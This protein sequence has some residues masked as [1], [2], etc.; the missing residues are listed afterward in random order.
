[1][2]KSDLR[3]SLLML[4]IALLYACTSKNITSTHMPQPTGTIVNDSQDEGEGNALE[5]EL[6][7]E[8][9]H[10]TA[11]GQ[12]WRDIERKNAIKK[13]V[14]TNPTRDNGLVILGDSLYTG[15]WA[16][17]GSKNQAGS[18]IAVEYLV[19][20]NKIYTISSGGTLW[21]GD[22]DGSNWEVINESFIFDS[23]DLRFIDLPN[24][25]KRMIL[26]IARIPH[27][28]DDMG[29]TWTAS[30]GVT[31]SGDF[32][33]R[34]GKF[35]T[36]TLADGSTRLYCLSKYDFWTNIDMYVSEDYGQ[37]YQK[38]RNMFVRDFNRIAFCK[39]HHGN[40]ILI[41]RANAPDKMRIDK[42]DEENIDLSFL[43]ITDVNLT[44]VT[45]QIILIA[46]YQNQDSILYAVQ[47]QNTLMRSN[48]MGQT[49]QSTAIFQDAPWDVGF[50]VSP[51]NPNA[52]YYG[53]VEAH[54]LSGSNFQPVNFWWEYYDDVV[55]YIHADIMSYNEF[56][57]PNGD[58]FLLIANH[59]GLSISR[60][61]LQTTRNISLEG[62][63]VSQYYDVVTDPNNSDFA[64]AGTQDQG[65]QRSRDMNSPGI[66][67]F[68]QVISGDYGHLTFSREGQGLW[69]V[70]PGGTIY[71]YNNPQ[72][73]FAV[74]T[75]E[76]ES[77]DES[78]WLP[79][80][81]AIPSSTENE[82]LVAGGSIDGGAGSHIIKLNYFGGISA[83]QFPFNFTENSDD[84]V[85]TSIEVSP[86]NPNIIYAATNNGF[87]FTSTDGGQNFE[88]G[89]N[90]VNNGHFLYGASIYAST[91]NENEVWIAGSGYNGDGVFYSDDFGQNFSLFTEGLPST[92]VFEIAANADETQFYAATEAGPYIYLAETQRWEDMSQGYTPAHTYWSVEYIESLD[93]VRFGTYGRGIWD[94]EF[95][96]PVSVNTTSLPLHH[97]AKV[98]PNPVQD[99]LNIEALDALGSTDQALQMEVYS[100]DGQ[101]MR[102]Q[103]IQHAQERID[104]SQLATGSYV[105]RLHDGKQ[106]QVENIIKL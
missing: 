78:S 31:T 101:L 42:I 59:G 53:E 77:V 39:P 30:V 106:M 97:F 7:I 6:W 17:K 52:V 5:R 61:Y 76:I 92:L 34:T 50:Y 95:K 2:N 55:N 15:E 100:T 4:G 71:F 16:E 10:Y 66:V 72:N 3:Y 28:S 73:G 21:K 84:G 54:R 12:N 87:F 105:I 9:M 32:W 90:A 82:I 96:A 23:N 103:K 63:N 70:F 8:N 67:N 58:P 89:F 98:Y 37:T 18:V 85:I 57:D 19:D 99:V 46:T 60:D 44:S 41:G 24:G 104:L 80:M 27:Y 47:N 11:P 14:Q 1:M 83:E 93:K 51:S 25:N 35:E 13:G 45:D 43:R 38:I 91:I 75:Y 29:V 26:S 74:D 88:L 33:S 48:D 22:L 20:E 40:E 36:I 49:W 64:Y 86:I 94:F 79:A 102:T 56:V 62:L 69:M 81:A 65:F 68:D